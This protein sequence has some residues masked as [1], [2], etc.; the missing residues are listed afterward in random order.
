MSTPNLP[1]KVTYLSD[2]MTCA[3]V[4]VADDAILYNNADESL[5]RFYA[6][7]FCAGKGC[8]YWIE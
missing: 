4:R 5:V 7:A 8:D 3:F 2:S 1:Y 6:D